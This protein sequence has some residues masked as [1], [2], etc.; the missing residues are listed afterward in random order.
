MGLGASPP[1]GV[2]G[3]LGKGKAE[4]QDWDVDEGERNGISVLSEETQMPQPKSF[5]PVYIE[6]NIFPFYN[7]KH[8]EGKNT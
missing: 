7:F 5:F 2:K 8:F 3:R 4:R 1:C 6:N